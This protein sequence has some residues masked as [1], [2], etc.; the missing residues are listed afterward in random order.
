MGFAEG[1]EDGE[2]ARERLHELGVSRRSVIWLARRGTQSVDG[3]A[4][5]V[6]WVQRKC[7]DGCPWVTEARFDALARL[8]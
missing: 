2:T 1:L 3:L 4:P 6:G 8:R 7:C 5:G